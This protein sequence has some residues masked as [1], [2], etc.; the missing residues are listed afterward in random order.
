MKA[1][2]KEVEGGVE[3][4][5]IAEDIPAGTKTAK[6]IKQGGEMIV[7]TLKAIVETGK[8]PLGVRAMYVAFKLMEPF[9]PKKTLSTH[10]Q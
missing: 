6:N 4:S 8:P 10:W 7:K 1:E 9:S 2:L 3:F 5:L